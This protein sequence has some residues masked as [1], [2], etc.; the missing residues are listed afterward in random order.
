MAKYTFREI[1]FS[2][3]IGFQDSSYI[4]V[5]N[6]DRIPPHLGFSTGKHYFSL[7][8]KGNEQKSVSGM[9]GKATRLKIPLLFIE[10]P[11]EIIQE[12]PEL[13]FSSFEK[14][15]ATNFT[16]LSPIRELLGM[17]ET[18]QQLANLLTEFDARKL[19]FNV[20][21]LHL[22]KTYRELPEY[23]VEDIVSRIQDLNHVKR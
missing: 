1:T 21:A 22:D 9:L 15:D 2:K 23:S 12:N 14:A 4:W 13:V 10:V 5:W 16:C 6:C 8:Y 17:N 19:A 3:P 20:F 11:K 18:I 7:T